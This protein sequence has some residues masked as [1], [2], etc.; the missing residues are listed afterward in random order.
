MLTCHT[1]IGVTCRMCERHNCTS[2]AFPPMTQP[3]KIDANL[4]KLSAFEFQ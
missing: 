2:R 4:K 1:P 3:L